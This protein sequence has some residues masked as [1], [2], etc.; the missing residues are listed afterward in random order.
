MWVEYLLGPLII[1]QLSAY[2]SV[3]HSVWMVSVFQ[4]DR[5]LSD[6]SGDILMCQMCQLFC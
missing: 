1:T 3:E 6:C 4:N 5:S 2:D